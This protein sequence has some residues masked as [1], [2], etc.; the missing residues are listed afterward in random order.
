MWAKLHAGERVLAVEE[1]E[2][3][4]LGGVEPAGDGV[5]GGSAWDG[6]FDAADGRVVAD[7][8]V[9]DPAR[10]PV[11]DGGVGG[12]SGRRN[13][14]RGVAPGTVWYYLATC[15]NWYAGR[16]SNPRPSD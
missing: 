9:L 6:E 1:S 12:G 5:G 14:L 16:D 10:G 7:R 2:F 15:G 11:D 4:A 3:E 13:A 8:V